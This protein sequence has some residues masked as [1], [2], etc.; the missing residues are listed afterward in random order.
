[1]D[2]A[3]IIK[4]NLYIFLMFMT[5]L[6]NYD[7]S[8]IESDNVLIRHKYENALYFISYLF[9]KTFIIFCV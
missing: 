5:L 1:M 8:D 4:G 6:Q 9:K 3:K 7:L 2:M